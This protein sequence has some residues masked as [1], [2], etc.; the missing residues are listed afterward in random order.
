MQQQ[1]T[2]QP[3]LKKGLEMFSKV[4]QSTVNDFDCRAYKSVDIAM[5]K[6]QFEGR[7]YVSFSLKWLD[8]GGY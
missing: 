4:S 1:R 7:E 3:K 6:R 5:E 8:Q 2:L